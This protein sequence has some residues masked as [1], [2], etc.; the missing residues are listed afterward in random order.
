MVDVVGDLGIRSALVRQESLCRETA[1][2]TQ[3]ERNRADID[4]KRV[5]VAFGG[6]RFASPYGRIAGLASHSCPFS[7]PFQYTDGRTWALSHQA[8]R[9]GRVPLRIEGGNVGASLP[10]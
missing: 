8:V 6:Q 10:P 5:V 2:A 9:V 4:C 3:I 1:E 7:M